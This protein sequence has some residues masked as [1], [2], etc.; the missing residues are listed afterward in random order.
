MS[1]PNGQV[2]DSARLS[3]PGSNKGLLRTA[4]L[5]Y[6]AVDLIVSE[7][8]A[9]YDG[10]VG[11]T[12]RT[13]AMQVLAKQIYGSN[14]ATPG[15][16]NHGYALAVDLQSYAQ[17]QAMDRVGARFGWAKAWSD[18]SWEWWHLKWRAGVWAPRPDPRRV[19]T[20][21]QRRAVNTL[22]YRRRQRIKEA[23]SGRGAR[24]RY[25]NR[26]VGRSYNRVRTLWKQA[27]NPARKRVLRIA[28]DDRNG[29]I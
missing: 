12:Y 14:A 18:A 22:L 25:W 24:W 8:M 29:R 3:L 9:I 23:A 7:N 5:A 1:Y 17:R 20:R 4:A 6:R 28:L 19:L 10:S 11:R 15:T 2:P 26:L 16:S 13:Y 21:K 27:D